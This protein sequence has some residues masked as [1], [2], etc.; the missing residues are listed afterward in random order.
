MKLACMMMGQSMGGGIV[1]WMLHAARL[2]YKRRGMG[3]A[4]IRKRKALQVRTKNCTR[5]LGYETRHGTYRTQASLVLSSLPRHVAFY[6]DAQ[7]QAWPCT[8]H[9][10]LSPEPRQS[11]CTYEVS[12]WIRCR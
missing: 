2:S 4:F 11:H 12:T 9:T 3:L 7:V 5:S 6:L 8:V 10:Q 1:F